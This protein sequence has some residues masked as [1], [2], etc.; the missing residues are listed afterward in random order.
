MPEGDTIHRA[1]RTLHRALAG[2]AVTSFETALAHIH[3]VHENRPI[4]GQSVTGVAARGKHLLITFSSGWVLRTH[5]RMSGSWHIYQPGE[6]WR[7][8]RSAARIVIRT[9]AYVAVAF[10]VPVAE[11]LSPGDLTRKAALTT[12]GPDLLDEAFDEAEACARLR[13]STHATV[14]EALLDQRAV[15]GIGNV[16]KS[17]VLFLSRLSPLAPPATL[18]ESDWLGLL[19]EGRR[20][21]R[22]NVVEPTAGGAWSYRGMRRTTGRSDPRARLWVYGREGEPCR[23]CGTTIVRVSQGE[24]NRS[25]YYCPRCQR[26][27]GAVVGGP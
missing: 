21:L 12:L 6:R 7:R 26:G 4:T 11:F 20:L 9:D 24:H 18:T 27:P 25:T 16:F 23:R 2:R 1:A 5:M 3:V 15:A 10:D 13:A 8:H 14:A 22:A 19:R 17:E